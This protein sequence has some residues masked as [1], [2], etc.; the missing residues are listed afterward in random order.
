MTETVEIIFTRTWW[1]YTADDGQWFTFLY[2]WFNIL[3]GIAWSVLAVLV[4]RRWNTHRY[5]ILE[6]WYTAAFVAFAVTDFREAWAQSSWLIWLKL[7]NL[8]M[9]FLLRRTVMSRF[10]P[11]AKVY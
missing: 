2:H 5:S 8:I 10:Y 11:Q 4:F 7:A 6:V 9:L 1:R 3:E